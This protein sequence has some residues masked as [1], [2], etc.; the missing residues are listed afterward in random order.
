MTHLPAGVRFRV[1]E[2]RLDDNTFTLEGETRSHSDAE[3]I[4]AALR[5]RS[6]FSVASPRT[7]QRPG[8]G[9]GF[10]LT[11]GVAAPA[12]AASRNLEQRASR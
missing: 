3:A 8:R 9:V 11:G 6:G 7:E 2:I 1:T 5:R 10:T 4:A 12:P